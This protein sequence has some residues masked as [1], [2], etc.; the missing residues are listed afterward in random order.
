[1]TENDRKLDD[2]RAYRAYQEQRNTAMPAA[3]ALGG[4]Y[5]VDYA[6]ESA[7]AGVKRDDPMLAWS[8]LHQAASLAS[9]S[10][11]TAPTL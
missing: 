1:M 11:Y 6:R 10:P 7:N 4:N 8:N 9:L 2:V 5:G 3:A